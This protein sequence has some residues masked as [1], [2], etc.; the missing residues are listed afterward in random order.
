MPVIKEFGPAED[1]RWT[2]RFGLDNRVQ[3]YRGFKE[4]WHATPNSPPS[5][6]VKAGNGCNAGYASWNGATDVTAWEIRVGPSENE[7][8][9]VGHVEYR[10]FETKFGVPGTCAQA[11][12]LEDDRVVGISNVACI[13]EEQMS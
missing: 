4:N 9:R 5:L 10:G 1:I 2:A 12:A 7:L 3:S 11:I 13:G 8:S 6:V